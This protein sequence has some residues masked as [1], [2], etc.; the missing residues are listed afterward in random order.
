MSTIFVVG[1][2]TR[3]IASFVDLL[4]AH[5]I[6]LLV[7]IRTIPRSRYNPQFNEDSL[8]KKMKDNKID[9]LHMKGLGGLR[10]SDKNSINLGWHNLSFRGFADYMQTK[11]FNSSIK[12]LIKLSKTRIVAIMCAEGNPFRCH[13]SLVADALLVRHVKALHISSKI[14]AREHVLTPFARVSGKKITYP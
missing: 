4:K 13:R 6:N 7:D 12:E 11:E 2:S 14:S 9:Y 10:H 8:K 1:H 3:T 5:S